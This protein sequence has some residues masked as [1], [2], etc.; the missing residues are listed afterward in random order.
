[1]PFVAIPLSPNRKKST[2]EAPEWRQDYVAN[3]RAAL[4]D[5]LS[6]IPFTSSQFMTPLIVYYSASEPKLQDGEYV[7]GSDFYRKGGLDQELGKSS[8]TPYD[9]ILVPTKLQ[10]TPYSSN[11]VEVQTQYVLYAPLLTVLKRNTVPENTWGSDVTFISTDKPMYLKDAVCIET[12]PH[13]DTGE[14]FTQNITSQHIRM[15]DLVTSKNKDS[16]LRK[17]ENAQSKWGQHPIMDAL[18]KNVQNVCVSDRD[19]LRIRDII[20]TSSLNSAPLFYFNGCTDEQLLDHNQMSK[21]ADML[22]H[23]FLPDDSF[24]ITSVPHPESTGALLKNMARMDDAT[25][26]QLA[27]RQDIHPDI[28]HFT[29]VA[30]DAEFFRKAR[31]CAILDEFLDKS[32]TEA[33]NTGNPQRSLSYLFTIIDQKDPNGLL[34][35]CGILSQKDA[36][37]IFHNE[38]T[39]TERNEVNTHRQ[40]AVRY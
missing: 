38:L 23:A 2:Q 13:Q 32:A 28:R 7:V 14:A 16:L 36:E 18:I 1:M 21:M 40:S 9:S 22:S 19:M 6:G 25:L 8:A 33:E 34:V 26:G 39:E 30:Q 11:L 5:H 17:I 20:A 24:R 3:A 4:R 31:T 35:D 15:A 10:G 12:V 37:Y 27:Q 29:K